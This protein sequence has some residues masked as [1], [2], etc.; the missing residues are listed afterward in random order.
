M[1]VIRRLQP[2]DAAACFAL[3]TTRGWKTSEAK[4]RTMIDLGTAYG[5]HVGG[6]L[7]GAV[8]L[9]RFGTTLASIA[10]MVVSPEHGRRGLGRALM[11]RTLDDAGD[12]TVFLYASDMGQSLYSRLGF[13]EAGVSVRLDGQVRATFPTYPGLRPMRPD[14]LPLV[15]ALD[16]EA[17]G[18]QR[19][20]L[21]ELLFREADRAC[22]VQRDG[23]VVGFGLSS[24]FLSYRVSSPIV[25]RDDDTARVIASALAANESALV[26]FDLAPGERA[27][28]VWAEAAGLAVT[29]TRTLMVRGRLSLPGNRG[30]V[31]ALASRAYG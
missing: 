6:D 11:E 23:A 4:W 2:D 8:I 12:V 21:L 30:L 20:R 15:I 19:G 9:T 17:Q 13:V 1:H 27:L 26:R 5:I 14:D 18:A 24:V 25:A 28:R 22:V 10:M 3:S 16:E 7:E 29:G 31:R